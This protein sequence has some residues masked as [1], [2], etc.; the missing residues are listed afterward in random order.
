LLNRMIKAIEKPCN[1]LFNRIYPEI[2]VHLF[3]E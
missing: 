3:V 1:Q 2:I